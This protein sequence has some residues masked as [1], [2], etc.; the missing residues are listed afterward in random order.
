[1]IRSVRSVLHSLLNE[2]GTQLDDEA[3]RTLMTE[4]EHI[5]NSRP[6]T[7]D[8]LS[9]PT[10][11]EPLT[12]NHLLTGKSTVV[13][14][15]PGKFDSPDVYSRKRWRRVQYL[16]NQ[17]WT[18]WRK[19]CTNL[20]YRRQKWTDTRRNSQVGDIV[21]M[22]D[23]DLPRN[24]WPLARITKVYSSQDGLIRKVQVLTTKEGKHKTF[25]RPIHQLILILAKEEFN[26]CKTQA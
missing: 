9:D 11:A 15:P 21:L 8:N 12:P 25:D 2:L 3:F 18:R 24:Q 19:E 13:L 23:N 14:P 10:P 7:V 4:T 16:V 22:R 20:L 17:F 6:L 26:T 1:M 5:I